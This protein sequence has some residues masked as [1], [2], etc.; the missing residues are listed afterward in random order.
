MKRRA[1]LSLGTAGALGLL[2]ATRFPRTVLAQK[3]VPYGE[4]RLNLS[5]DFRDGSLY[6]PK[7]Y[8]PEVPMPL[9]IMLHGY[10]GTA[11]TVRYTFPIAEELGVVVIAPESR[12]LTWGQSIPGFDA[13]VKYIGAAYRYVEAGLNLDLTRI[14]LGGHSDGAGYALSMGLAYGDT[15][16]HLMVLSGGLMIPVRRQGKP[17]IFM[18]HGINDTQMPI[19][20]TARIFAPKL[21]EEGYDITYKEYEGGHGAPPF[22]VRDAFEWFVKSGK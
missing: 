8:N 11:Q 7:S 13:D 18:A 20:R 17:R 12:D 2:H 6:I 3:K 1:F 14:A 5:D 9:L 16:N 4:S 22:V 21:K 10:S 15:F 19:D